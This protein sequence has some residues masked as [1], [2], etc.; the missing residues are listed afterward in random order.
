MKTILG[1]DLGTTSIGWALVKEAENNN[2]KS[3]IRKLGVR[4]VPLSTDERDNFQ[5]GKSITTNAY[6]RLK[7]SMRRN[8]QRYKLRRAQLLQILKEEGWID[9][10]F[11]LAEQGPS[12]TFS[13]LRLR[14]KAVSEEISLQD[15]AKV[16]LQINKKRGYKSSRKLNQAEDGEAVD[17]MEVAEELFNQKQTPGEYVFERMKKGQYVIP[18]FYKSDLK[19]EFDKIWSFQKSFH[20]EE[21]S[22]SLYD[23]LSSCNKAQTWT[24]CHKRWN[25]EGK[26]STLKGKD[27]LFELYRL[28]KDALYKELELEDLT[29]VFQEINGQLSSLSGLLSNISDR[30][31]E[32]HFRKLTVGQKLL[33]II[34]QD[35]NAS[36]T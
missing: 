15:L 21:L 33:D 13:T 32:L 34:E 19:V 30:S 35:P 11:V 18:E 28:R 20:P 7:R 29:L 27:R 22:D 14:A 3:E 16:L 36:L 4:L 23:V 8:L 9:E 24:E 12:S 1:I 2:E 6:R 26:K 31:K 25:I 17:G 5:K 10:S